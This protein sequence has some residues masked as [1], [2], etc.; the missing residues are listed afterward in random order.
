MDVIG[1]IPARYGATRFEGKVLA[2][3]GGKPMVQWVWEAAKKARV[4]DDII[5]ACDDKRIEDAV[6]SFGGKAVFTSKEHPSG[7]D[8]ICEIVNPLDVK[9]VVNI[10][11]DE[12]LL[13]P[14][15]IE[16][17]ARPLLDDATLNITTLM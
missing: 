7:T 9:V 11:A 13:E 16:N 5:V 17:I 15:M 10:Q 3:I 4:L 14:V 1:I 12:P 2:D 8:R 6:N